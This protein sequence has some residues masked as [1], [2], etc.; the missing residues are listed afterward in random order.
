ML[1]FSLFFW[2]IV[3]RLYLSVKKEF[4]ITDIFLTFDKENHI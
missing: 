3:Q 1:H 2:S 4:K